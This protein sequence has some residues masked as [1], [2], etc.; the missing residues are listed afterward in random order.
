LHNKSRATINQNDNFLLK[1]V[2]KPVEW[3]LRLVRSDF[4]WLGHILLMGLRFAWRHHPGPVEGNPKEKIA[5]P[6]GPYAAKRRHQMGDLLIWVPQHLE[7]F[8]IDDLTGGFGYSH[9]TIDTGEVDLPTGKPVMAEVT[10]G[11]VVKR[12]FQDEYA[13]RPYARIPL[14]R[15][16]VDVEAFVAGVLSRLGEP[17]SDLKALTLGEIDDPA[18][19]VCSSLAAES[20][21]EKVRGKI[22]KARRL[23][24]LNRASVS[25][26]SHLNASE[27]KVFISPN[28]FAQYYEAPK[29]KKVHKADFKVEP[30]PMETSVKTMVRKHRWKG[31]LILGAAGAAIAAALL[32]VKHNRS[33]K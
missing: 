24:L 13:D 29:G 31:V 6:T 8:I 28:G 17:Y 2:L 30:H 26:H 19:Q 18:K 10:I 20:L 27:T 16:G 33:K 4:K 23:M 22:A 32:M 21:P 11:Q 12:K 1:I 9:V 25:V 15:T 7:S 14:S 5:T 3:I